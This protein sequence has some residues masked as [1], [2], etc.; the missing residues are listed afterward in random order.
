MKRAE[1]LLVRIWNLWIPSQAFWEPMVGCMRSAWWT[2]AFSSDVVFSVGQDM[3]WCSRWTRAC[4][5]PGLGA[6]DL[7][8]YCLSYP[9]LTW[10]LFSQGVLARR[11]FSNLPKGPLKGCPWMPL[12]VIV[13]RLICVESCSTIATQLGICGVLLSGLQQIWLPV[14]FSS[15]PPFT[16]LHWGYFK[17]VI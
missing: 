3:D 6:A 10:V 15:Q 11:T 16:W 4:A 14:L 9:S 2:S 7:S 13:T 1:I 8:W 5:S 12:S 17:P